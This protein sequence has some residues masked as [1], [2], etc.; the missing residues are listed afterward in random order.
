[1]KE[2]VSKRTEQGTILDSVFC[3]PKNLSHPNQLQ[4]MRAV[5]WLPYF[6]GRDLAGEVSHDSD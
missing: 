5:A 2:Q 4:Y 1:M 6:A 3:V